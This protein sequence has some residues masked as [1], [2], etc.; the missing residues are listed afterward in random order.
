MENETRPMSPNA[1]NPRLRLRAN[2]A[3]SGYGGTVTTSPAK[4]HPH[5]LD[6]DFW[7]GSLGDHV[8]LVGIVANRAPNSSHNFANHLA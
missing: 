6:D 8:E 4:S 5:S 3:S 1:C 7:L 2:R